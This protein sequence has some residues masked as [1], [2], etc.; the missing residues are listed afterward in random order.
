MP[1]CTAKINNLLDQ[2]KQALLRRRPS[3]LLRYSTDTLD[4][5]ILATDGRHNLLTSRGAS[6]KAYKMQ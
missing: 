6:P 1:D 4:T 5:D 3:I 2:Y